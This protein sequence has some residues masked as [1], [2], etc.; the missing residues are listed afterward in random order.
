MRFLTIAL[1]LALWVAAFGT[2]CKS[3]L[4][5]FGQSYQDES[6]PLYDAEVEYI[7]T[8]IPAYI[9]TKL[10][11]K[12]SYDI[13]VDGQ[14]LS[15]GGSS[16][17]TMVGNA[18]D[19]PGVLRYRTTSRSELLSALSSLPSTVGNGSWVYFPVPPT[20]R[21]K[22]AFGAS[23]A[24]LDDVLRVDGAILNNASSTIK[25][26]GYNVG[27]TQRQGKCR[28]FRFTIFEGT[29][30]VIDLIPVRIGTEGYM[31]DAVSGNVYGNSN[32]TGTIS[33]G[34]DVQR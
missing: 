29:T 14:W 23:G 27:N 9:D 15:A 26:A 13:V 21:H 11:L 16:L 34:P 4:G 6:A 7:D 24:Y 17:G 3:M 8:V 31:F 32:T 28:I 25:I 20:E 30:K 18:G 19:K 12:S 33:P 1:S 10:S 22:Y 5:S 2:P